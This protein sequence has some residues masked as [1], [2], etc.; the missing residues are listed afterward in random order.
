MAAGTL[1]GS[2]ALVPLLGTE[3]VPKADYSETF[4]SFH[5]PVGSSLELTEM[6]ARQVDAILREMPEVRYTLTTINTGQAQGRIYASVYVRLVDRHLRQRSVD[7]MSVPLRQRL[8]AVPGIQVTHVGLLDSVGGSK[9]ISISVQGADLVE[10]QRLY[11][12]LAARIG[13]VPG[14]IDLDTSMKANK[15]TV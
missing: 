13:A 4:V 10:L 14:V 11:A 15:P 3:F 7:Q 5:T 8:A 9:H 12:S 2:F 1:G 6:R